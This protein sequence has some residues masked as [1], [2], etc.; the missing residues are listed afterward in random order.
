MM[1]RG[2]LHE[3]SSISPQNV[4]CGIG[5]LPSLQWEDSKLTCYHHSVPGRMEERRD[6]VAL[7]QMSCRVGFVSHKRY[8]EACGRC[9]AGKKSELPKDGYC[10]DKDRTAARWE[11]LL[12]RGLGD[13]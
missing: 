10:I 7:T 5:A 4:K 1:Q 2:L 11:I 12:S 3:C 8:R 13:S 9:R 6:E